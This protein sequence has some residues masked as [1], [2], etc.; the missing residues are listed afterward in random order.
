MLSLS[1]GI[2]T[3]F[4]VFRLLHVCACVCTC[5]C[6]C[7]RACVCV[8]V[9]ACVCECVCVYI[10]VSLQVKGNLICDI[11]K[12]PILNLPDIDPAIVAAREEARRR[13]QPL[14]AIH[15]D[16]TLAD[17]VFDAIRV[18][19]I[20]VICCILFME[21]VSVTKAF[22]VGKIRVLNTRTSAG[23][24]LS[25]PYTRAHT[26][27][28]LAPSKPAY[29]HTHA[30]PVQRWQDIPLL[31]VYVC[32]CHMRRRCGGRAVL[33]PKCRTPRSVLRVAPC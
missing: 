16:P 11:C 30:C 13:R 31:C 1:H 8:Y 12:A 26:R 17:Y 22:A 6:V 5:V 2:Y 3:E 21:D 14:F 25:V 4:M 33:P 27:T 18:A 32:V 29:S 15:P 23:F 24:R 10:I 9:C 20:T 7:M 19:W 28:P